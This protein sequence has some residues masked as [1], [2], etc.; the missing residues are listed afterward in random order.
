MTGRASG[1]G[2]FRRGPVFFHTRRFLNH[3]RSK[4]QRFS[5]NGKA[6]HPDAEIFRSL[7]H[8]P[9]GGGSLQ[10]RGPNF[11][12]QRVLS[13]LLRQR[14]QHG[15]VSPDG[16]GPGPGRYDRR[17]LL[18]LRQHL[19]GLPEQGERPPQHRQRRDAVRG[20]QPGFDA[21][22]PTAGRLYS[23][24]LRRPGEP[25]DLRP[26]PGIFL[27]Y[28]PGHP[29]LHVR[30]GHEPHHPLGRQPRLRH[31][32]HPGRR[33]REHRAGPGVHLRL[34]V[35]HDGRRRGHRAGPGPHRRPGSVVSLPHEGRAAGKAELCALPEGR[36]EIH[37]PGRVQLPLPDL[38]GG[39]HGG[40][41]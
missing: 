22:I 7:R 12:R 41:Q 24:S 13:R 39:G 3:E 27:L 5:G 16:G 2:C 19:P 34:P 37:P 18:R 15:G 25:G 26:L 31:G 40:H 35:G 11:H 14:R 6:W 21:L 10:H 28:H 9:A 32:Q 1:S 20:C 17:R 8:L 36:P 23:D 30:P 33:R 4:R 29:L 38:P